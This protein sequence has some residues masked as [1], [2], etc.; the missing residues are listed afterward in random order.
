MFLSLNKL[1]LLGILFVVFVTITVIGYGY[2]SRW[3]YLLCVKT[4]SFLI[5]YYLFPRYVLIVLPFNKEKYMPS[6]IIKLASVSSLI[7]WVAVPLFGCIILYSPTLYFLYLLAISAVNAWYI[8]FFLSLI[9]KSPNEAII[10]SGNNAA[11]P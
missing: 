10:Q 5:Y 9:I 4:I 7:A 1:I 2:L 3:Q 6:E 8:L 11:N